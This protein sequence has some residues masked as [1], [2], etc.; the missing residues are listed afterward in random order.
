[1]D[2]KNKNIAFNNI[3]LQFNCP[4]ITTSRFEVIHNY[5][6]HKKGIILNMAN[7][8]EMIGGNAR[9]IDTTWFADMECEEQQIFFAQSNQQSILFRIA[10]IVNLQNYSMVLE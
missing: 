6:H 7:C 4:I 10:S 8:S 3:Y 5:Q 1:M 9:F 2:D